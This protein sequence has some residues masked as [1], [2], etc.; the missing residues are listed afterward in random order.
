[1]TT[2]EGRWMYDGKGIS[3]S[4]E[5]NRKTAYH[6]LLSAKAIKLWL[7]SAPLISLAHETWAWPFVVLRW[8]CH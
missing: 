2:M 4:G 6:S 3:V 8:H 1:M 7:G 5:I